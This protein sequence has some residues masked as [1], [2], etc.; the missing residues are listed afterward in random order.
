MVISHMKV[1]SWNPSRST[2]YQD[3]LE[4]IWM[5]PFMDCCVTLRVDVF[6]LALGRTPTNLA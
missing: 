2:K 3:L 6:L 5:A 4:T 1:L